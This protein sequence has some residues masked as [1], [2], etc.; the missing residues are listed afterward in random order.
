MKGGIGQL[1]KQAQQMQA[2]MQKAQEELARME[3]TG[4]SGG[5][6][7]KVVMNGKHEVRKVEIDAAL[8]EDDKEMLEDLVAAAI[9]DAVHRIERAS[10][11]RMSS[12]TSGMTL[13]PGMK[14]PF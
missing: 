3:V 9:N 8:Q 6:M 14:L 7:V 5:G 12:L 11:E 13:P 2:N 10:S 4:E 1:M